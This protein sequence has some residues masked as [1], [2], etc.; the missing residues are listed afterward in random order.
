MTTPAW[1]SAPTLP[2]TPMFGSF[3][4]TP[5]RNVAAF[6][7]D[8]GQSKQRRRSTASGSI[9]SAQF[10]VNDT[11]R[12]AL[13]TFYRTTLADG[14]LPFTW[15]HPISGTNYTWA[16]EEAPTYSNRGF[17]YHFAQCKLRRLP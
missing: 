1:P 5:Q 11:Q 4:E 17:N 2:Q 7:P 6:Q 15:N 14:T 13:D 10:E 8:V 16:F 9:C 12:A 3:D